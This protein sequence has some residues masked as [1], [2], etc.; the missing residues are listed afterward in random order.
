MTVEVLGGHGGNGSD[1]TAMDSEG[2]SHTYTGGA[3]GSGGRAFKSYT[4]TSGPSVGASIAIVI[5]ATSRFTSGTNPTAISGGDGQN[6]FMA[7]DGGDGGAPI[8]ANGNAG[9]DGTASGGDT[10]TTGGSAESAP[11]IVI[12]YADPVYDHLGAA[13]SAQAT[14]T[15]A[16]RVHRDMAGA[17]AS[18]ASA[19]AG[20]RVTHHLGGAAISTPTAA[21]TLDV[22]SAGQSHLGAA[23]KAQPGFIAGLGIVKPLAAY[24]VSDAEVI[25]NWRVSKHMSAAAQTSAII[26][27]A[28]EVHAANVKHL[29]AGAT[30]ASAAQASLTS[31]VP[32]L[33]VPIANMA[34]DLLEEEPIVSADDNRTAVRWMARNFGPIRDAM[35][36]S[37]PWNW[38]IK[39]AALDVEVTAPASGWSYGYLLPSDFIRL[40]PLTGGY[41]NG[42]DVPFALEGQRI[43]TNAGTS[44][45]IVYVARVVDETKMDPIFVQALAATVASR[46]ASFITGKTSYMQLCQQLAKDL[47]LQAQMV[48]A[49]EGT[50]AEAAGD[51]WIN[52]RSGYNYSNSGNGWS[53]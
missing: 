14:A 46:A 18:T 37:H 3:G 33:S 48:D 45:K 43:L 21:G 49:L 32:I 44:A 7:S 39:R 4:P 16:A 22:Q 42:A 35:L 29:S 40:V 9:A 28:L 34:L 5:G 30:G 2:G 31:G 50:P 38:A 51:D 12:T 10:N 23:A 11:K 53:Y 15:G 24:G 25:A 1:L 26:S 8:Y 13:A 52:G 27:A 19:Q 20:A 47:T 6:A 17:A 36:R 41:L